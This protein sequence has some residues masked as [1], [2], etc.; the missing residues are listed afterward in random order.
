VTA[1]PSLETAP[2]HHQ[3]KFDCSVADGQN[4]AFR[5]R[6]SGEAYGSRDRSNRN[7]CRIPSEAGE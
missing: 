4:K 3:A 2:Q 5:R 1:V 6:K 7:L